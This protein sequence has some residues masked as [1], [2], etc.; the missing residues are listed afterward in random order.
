MKQFIK[1]FA[2]VTLSF[3]AVIAFISFEPN[4]STWD[5]AGRGAFLFFSFVFSFTGTLV[6]VADTNKK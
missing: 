6:A 1:N 2:L 4:I 3:Y 5:T